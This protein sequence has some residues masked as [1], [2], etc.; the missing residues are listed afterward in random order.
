[1]FPRWIRILSL[2]LSL[3]LSVLNQTLG[4]GSRGDPQGILLRCYSQNIDSMEC[5]V[6]C[7]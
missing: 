2:S 6:A 7:A 5:Q 3:S 1:M 4:L